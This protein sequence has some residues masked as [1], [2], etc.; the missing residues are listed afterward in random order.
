VAAAT[1]KRISQ[2]MGFFRIEVI[3]REGMSWQSYRLGFN[4]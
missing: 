3:A 1:G 4:E 2:K